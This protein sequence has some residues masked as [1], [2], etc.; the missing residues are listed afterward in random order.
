[1]S[2]RLGAMA[3]TY[4]LE[5]HGTQR[6]SYTHKQFAQRYRQVFGDAPELEDFINHKKI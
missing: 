3:A 2:G 4:V 1:V 6:H 5:Q